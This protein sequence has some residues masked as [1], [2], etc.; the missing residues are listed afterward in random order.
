MKTTETQIVKINHKDFG[1]EATEAQKITKGLSNIL[2]ERD[3]LS[4][5]YAKVIV[6]EINE[7]N[8]STFR[9]LRLLIRDNRTKGFEPWRKTN[10]EYFLRGGQFVDAIGKKECEENNRM[11]EQLLKGEKYLENIEA[12]RKVKLIEEREKALEKYEVETEYMQLG[13][14]TQD[15]WENYFEG[16]KL[17][18]EKKIEDERKVEEERIKKEQEDKLHEERTKVLYDYMQFIEDK[19]KDYGAMSEKDFDVILKGLKGEK[20]KYDKKQEAI[21]KENER[22]QKEVEAKKAQAK[23]ESEAAAEKIK[24][25]TEAR[26]KA[27]TELKAK[28]DA[29]AKAEQEKQAKIEAELSKGDKEKFQSIVDDLTELK[30][31]YTFKSKKFRTLQSQIN[32]L[33]DKI[34]TFSKSKV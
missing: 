30:G 25:E 1:I 31:K 28:K 6:L 29:E 2:K 21:R 20:V 27:E 11:E 24:K 4:K 14:M 17:Q 19:D 33:I 26:V 34:L 32:Q 9:N 5:Q 22:L 12:E 10:K 23:K 18:Y 15:V 3:I 7:E 8:I 13:E 16:V